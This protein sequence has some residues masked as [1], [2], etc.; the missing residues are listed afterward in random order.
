MQHASLEYAYQYGRPPDRHPSIVHLVIKTKSKLE[1]LREKLNL[2][3]I[4]TSEFHESYMDW[5]L[6]AIACQL[7][8]EQRHHLKGL[9]LWKLPTQNKELV[10]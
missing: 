10:I 1:N 7:N 4:V 5:G 8:E 3:G 2:A 6:T 9:Q